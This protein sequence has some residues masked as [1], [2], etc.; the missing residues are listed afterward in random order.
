MCTY[1]YLYVSCFCFAVKLHFPPVNQQNVTCPTCPHTHTALLQHL[2]CIY[3]IAST[4]LSS[5]VFAFD[6]LLNGLLY[7]LRLAKQPQAGTLTVSQEVLW[8][9]LFESF[10]FLLLRFCAPPM[11]RCLGVKNKVQVFAA[12]SPKLESFYTQQ[13]R[14]PTQVGLKSVRSSARLVAHFWCDLEEVVWARWKRTNMREVLTFTN[15]H[16]KHLVPIS[17]VMMI[18]VSSTEEHEGCDG[19]TSLFLENSAWGKTHHIYRRYTHTHYSL[20]AFG[21]NAA[22]RVL[23]FAYSL[24]V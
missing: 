20:S 18:W 8:Y 23:I 21:S 5:E 1:V 4:Y 7:T 19:Y 22:R 2:H 9:H 6:W 3:S 24:F 11:A 16:F 17:L 12:P 10:V 15:D 13:S 14:Q